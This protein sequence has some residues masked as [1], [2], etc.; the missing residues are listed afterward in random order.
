MKS[1]SVYKVSLNTPKDIDESTE[2]DIVV[3]EIYT[4]YF[5]EDDIMYLF[6]EESN[7]FCDI[8]FF[9][10]GSLENK[11]YNFFNEINKF[12]K[13]WVIDIKNITD[14]I[15]IKNEYLDK[16]QLVIDYVYENL[17]KD[18]I[19]DKINLIGFENIS[20]YDLEILSK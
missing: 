13:N 2:Q 11:V 9:L 20:K 4:K 18:D 1:L 14:D 3:R 17:T 15:L 16:N 7:D 6:Q 5:S 19:L 8:Y 12:N 10:P